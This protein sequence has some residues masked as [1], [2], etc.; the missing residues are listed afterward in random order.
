MNQLIFKTDAIP[1]SPVCFQRIVTVFEFFLQNVPANKNVIF[2]RC[3][4]W[5]IRYVFGTKIFEI[6]CMSGNLNKK[7]LLVIFLANA[8]TVTTYLKS[9]THHP[10]GGQ[11]YMGWFFYEK[12]S[13]LLSR[14]VAVVTLID[15]KVHFD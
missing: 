13:P 14:R 7:I 12:Q 2:E 11:K 10:P 6:N 15:T 8:N 5:K 1:V 4:F 9:G 3:N